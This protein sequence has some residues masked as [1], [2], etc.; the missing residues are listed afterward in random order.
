M[1]EK[2]LKHH[3]NYLNE[4]INALKNRCKNF[5]K[6]KNIAEYCLEEKVITDNFL[7]TII[8]LCEVNNDR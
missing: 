6:I 4:Q 1:N 5:K 7:R 8:K 2:N 3:I